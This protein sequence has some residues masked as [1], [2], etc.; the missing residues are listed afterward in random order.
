MLYVYMSYI[1]TH[2]RH[3]LALD[4]VTGLVKFK[5]ASYNDVLRQVEIRKFSKFISL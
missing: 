2:T 1:W 5:D 4:T 3:T